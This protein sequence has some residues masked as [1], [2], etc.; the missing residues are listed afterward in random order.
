M[1]R[2]PQPD[3]AAAARTQ[4]L[5]R[6]GL[7][8]G[9]GD[10]VLEDTHR[11]IGEFLDGAPEALQG[12][13]ERRRVE[14]DRVLGLLTGSEADLVELAAAR[15]PAAP[16]AARIP[17]WGKWL[18]G[19]ALVAGIGSGV[20]FLGRP[21][22]DLPAM[23]AAASAS[24]SAPALDQAKVAELMA[25]VQANP[26]DTAALTSLADLY[27]AAA[28]YAT[29][30]TFLTK[31]LAYD[32]TN[33]KALV[34]HGAAAFNQGDLAAAEKAW[35]QAVALYPTN[36]EAHYDL[37]FL[38]MTTQRTD[39]MKAAW[40]KVVEIAPES[41][42]ATTVKSHVGSVKEGVAGATASAQPSP[43]PSK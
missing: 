2:A 37:G 40:A 1:S 24:P 20:Y 30:D 5:G 7:P 17:T 4:L 13:A 10:D 35:D 11:Q 19:L 22:T 14:S 36:V 26:Q 41:S 3:A 16:A 43:E 15:T 21:P 29:A 32:A 33:E 27:F 9:T 28:D 42:Y 25:K 34:A 38:Y 6:L 8:E 39:Q 12:W 31:I 23:T 18:I